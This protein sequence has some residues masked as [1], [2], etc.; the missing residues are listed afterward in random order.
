MMQQNLSR[1]PPPPAT[2]APKQ[3]I[4]KEMSSADPR[5]AGQNTYMKIHI[6]NTYTYIHKYI[7]IHIKSA[8]IYIIRQKLRQK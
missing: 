3:Y 1:P 2:S 5:Q 4:N 8:W 7:E 6:E